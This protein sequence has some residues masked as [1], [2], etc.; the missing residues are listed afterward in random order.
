MERQIDKPRQ[1]CKLVCWFA[2]AVGSALLIPWQRT[3]R[4]GATP[5]K[6]RLDPR[7]NN[8]IAITIVSYLT[9]RNLCTRSP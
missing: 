4:R 8:Q 1:I 9:G 7:D 3:I 2:A 5:V 6:Q